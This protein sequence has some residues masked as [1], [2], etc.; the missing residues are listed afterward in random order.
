MRSIWFI[1]VALAMIG[2]DEQASPLPSAGGT[3]RWIVQGEGFYLGSY[4]RWGGTAVAPGECLV[5][6]AASF[7]CGFDD[8]NEFFFESAHCDTQ[9]LTSVGFDHAGHA[10]FV[11]LMIE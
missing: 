11:H 3:A 10:V 8:E 4:G 2:C 6:C 5:D 9:G 7:V 1:I